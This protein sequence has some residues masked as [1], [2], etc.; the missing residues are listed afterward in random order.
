M[1]SALW[2]IYWRAAGIIVPP[3]DIQFVLYALHRL[4]WG[5]VYSLALVASISDG[6]RLDINIVKM[7]YAC[8]RR[9]ILGG[10]IVMI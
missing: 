7:T 8:L 1:A 10:N 4:K 6:M 3:I 9:S 5:G 2:G